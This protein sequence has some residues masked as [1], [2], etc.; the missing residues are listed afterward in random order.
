MST[1]PDPNRIGGIEWTRRTKGRLTR[2]EQLQLLGAIVNSQRDYF[3]N[4]LR[5]TRPGTRARATDREIRPPDSRFAREAEAAAAEQSPVIVGH[6][7]RSWI[8][9][10]ALADVDGVA[11]DDELLY[12][13]CLLHDHG[14]APVVPGEDFT[15][16]SA[17]RAIECAT[18]AQLDDQRATQ[19]AD[20]ITVHTTPGVSVERDGP[21]GYYIQT[22][23]MV[24]IVGN[25]IWDLSARLVDDTLA[26]Y[27]RS[28]FT[29]ELA[30]HFTAEAKAVGR[31]RFALV[32]RCGFIPLMHMAPFDRK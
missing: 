2:R 24:D 14:I 8:F 19:L 16:R 28:G 3:L 12:A 5:G 26:R 29:R 13:G 23:A 10:R 20:A 21:I 18:S 25:R 4:R 27:D 7:Y 1:G 9:G 30:A 17:R 32:R 6:S 15:V 11:V 31:G 22:G